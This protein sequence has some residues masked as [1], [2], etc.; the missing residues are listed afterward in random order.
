MVILSLLMGMIKHCQISQSNKFAISFQHLEKYVMYGVHFWHP[1][2]TSQ[3][4]Q[5]GI[6]VFDGSRQTC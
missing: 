2:K 5:V 1:D 3:F 6:F 4:L